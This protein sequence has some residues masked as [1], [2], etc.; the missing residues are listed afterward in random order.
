[1]GQL[2]NIQFPWGTITPSTQTEEY[3]KSG[4][5]KAGVYVTDIPGGAPDGLKDQARTA[6]SQFKDFIQ[7]P[8]GMITILGGSAL[9]LLLI[10]QQRRR[11]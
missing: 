9:V 2:F 3:L 4:L 5:E 6:M 1:M 8:M 7:T 11:R 10:F